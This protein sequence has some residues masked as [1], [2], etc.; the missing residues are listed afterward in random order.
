MAVPPGLTEREF[1]RALDEFAAAVGR[2]WVFASDED[3]NLY[4]DAYSPFWSEAEDRVPSAAVAPDS[5]EQVQAIVRIANTYKIPLWTVSTGRNLGYGGASPAYS[6]SV[7]VDLKRM[8]RILE[9]NDK[10][11]YAVVEPGVSYF[12]LYRYI[13][14]RKLNVWID[15]ADPGWGSPVGNALERGGGR[16][17]MRD[18]WNAV[19]GLEVV[20]ANGEVLRTGMGA[21]P[22][23]EVWHQYKYG[24]GPLV[25]GLFSQ[26]NFGIVTRMGIWLMP[27]PEAY[28]DGT[29]MVPQHDDLIPFMETYAYL[30]NSDILRGT[31][32]LESPLLNYHASQGGS[33]FEMPSGPSIAELDRLARERNLP[34]WSAQFRFWGP[35]RVIDAEW[36]YVKEKF[37]AIPGVSFSDGRNYRFPADVDETDSTLLVALGIPNL[38]VFGLLQGGGHLGVS[39]IIP[40]TGEAIFKAQKVYGQLYAELGLPVG[41]QFAALPWSYSPRALVLLFGIPTSHDVVRNR[42]GRQIFERLVQVS[43]ENGWAEYRTHVAFM[44]EVAETYSF[45]NH[46]MRRF[47]ETL[48]DAVDPN[49]I[50]SPGK[51][52]IWPKRLRDA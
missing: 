16:T 17:P 46:A 26:S 4:R 31:M 11:H 21:L 34:Y 19:C 39:P 51:S 8:N 24:F 33:F 20:L 41:N 7:V 44:D 22:G 43:A 50:L 3:M 30:L 38:G 45:N 42:Q 48:K 5:V 18:H 2:E 23:S 32:L 37:A 52:G 1:S 47:H 49:G 29:V 36:E 9:V 6:G 15:P 13:Q 14:D 12:D 25:D 27:A 40:M 10:I 28:R 35:P